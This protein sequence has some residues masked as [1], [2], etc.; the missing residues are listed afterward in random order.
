M[1]RT[2]FEKNDRGDTVFHYECEE[3]G[4]TIKERSGKSGW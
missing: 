1:R 3:C 2:G 4:D